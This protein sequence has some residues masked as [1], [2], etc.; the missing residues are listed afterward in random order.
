MFEY[1]S[2]LYDAAT[3][4]RMA[5][6]FLT[7]LAAAL[8]APQRPVTQLPLL[9]E[10]EIAEEARWND[11]ARALPDDATI[12]AQ[13][14][15]QVARTPEATALVFGE[16]AMSYRELDLRAMNA[17]VKPRRRTVDGWPPTMIVFA[18]CCMPWL[19]QYHM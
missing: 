15:V 9:T 13:V 1:G 2:D 14:A 18:V 19:P 7:L 3:I 6:H 8:D 10:A 12:A 4:R 17:G 5:G 16:R 11:T